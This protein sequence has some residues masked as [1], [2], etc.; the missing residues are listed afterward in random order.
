MA[1]LI[2]SLLLVVCVSLVTNLFLLRNLISESN[3]SPKSKQDSAKDT[4]DE[5]RNGPS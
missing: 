3:V 4:I 5:V 1:L 2:G